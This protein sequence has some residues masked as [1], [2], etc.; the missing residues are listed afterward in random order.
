VN[1]EDFREYGDFCDPTSPYATEIVAE[2]SNPSVGYYISLSHG[3]PDYMRILADG[4]NTIGCPSPTFTSDLF[5]YDEPHHGVYDADIA[6]VSNGGR[7]YVHSS[8]ACDP[9]AFDCLDWNNDLY[10][11]C[12]AEKDLETVGGSVAG[13]YNTRYGLVYSSYYLEMTRIE[14]LMSSAADHR[15]GA[16]HYATK[17]PHATY[18]LDLVYT[19]NLFGDPEFCIYTEDPRSFSV[20]HPSSFEYNLVDTITI[21]V[22][23]SVYAIGV[24]DVLVTLCK[25]GEIYERGFTNATGYLSLVTYPTTLGKVS[26]CCSKDG[27]KEL[28]DSINVTYCTD[29]VAGDANGSGACTGP[30]VTFLTNYFRGLVTPPD[31]CMCPTNRLYHAAD[32][33]GDCSLLGSDVTYLVNFFG[34]GPAPHICTSCPGYSALAKRKVIPTEE[35]KRISNLK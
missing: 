31:S 1:T 29:A 9:G 28:S 22:V 11:T 23:D 2:L 32:A 25:D 24:A 30:D 14:A 18:E 33:N 12:F 19:N 10:D 26:L 8:I 3:S 34:G 20:T 4:D 27:Y 7:E 15:F 13:T 21:R 17:V 6:E 16:A 5:A 35:A